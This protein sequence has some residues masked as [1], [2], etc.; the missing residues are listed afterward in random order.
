VKTAEGKLAARVK[1]LLAMMGS[2]NVGEREN[3][4][5]LLAELLRKHKKN[6]NDLVEL[7]QTGN[8]GAWN[9]PGDPRDATATPSG[10]KVNALDLVHH[11]LQSYVGMKPDEYVAVALW[12]IHTHVYDRFMISPRLAVT[13]P[14]RGCGKTIL[15]D[16]I[17]CMV[18]RARKTDG[19]SAAAIYRLVDREHCSLLVDEADNLG[20]HVDGPL[21]ATFNSGHRKGGRIMRGWKDGVREYSV[22]SPMAIAA[23]GYLPLP[24]SHRSITIHMTRY[25]GAEPLRRFDDMDT[26][27]LDIA[28]QQ[29]WMWSKKANLNPDPDMPATLRNRQAD[30]WRPLIAIA[31][32]FGTCWAEAARNAA[33]AFSRGHR[34]EDVGVILLRDIRDLFDAHRADRFTSAALVNALNEMDSAPWSEWRGARDDRSPRKLSQGELAKLLSP[35]HIR[36]KSIWPARRHDTGRSSA[37]G[38]V[39][40]QFEQAWSAYCDEAGTPAHSRKNIRLVGG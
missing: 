39:R 11:L 8:A 21:R 33:L 4:R 10:V 22:Y 40:L 1:A 18:P 31:D 26:E 32:T 9:I 15:L 12:I 27:D 37:K 14:V 23:I 34:D 13:S 7:M 36:P 30:N 5:A 16:V 25:A 35:F 24:I 2:D 19:I 28:Y 3:A 38:Y 6:W 29:I 17:R 20:L